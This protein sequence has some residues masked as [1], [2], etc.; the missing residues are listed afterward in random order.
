MLLQT[1]QCLQFG[2]HAKLK[3]N[4][5]NFYASLYRS[6]CSSDEAQLNNFFRPLNIPSIV[7]D[8]SSRL[9][10][11][12]TVEEVKAAL[13]SMQNGKCP[14]PDGLPTEFFKIFADKL[15]PLLL[16]MFNELSRVGRNT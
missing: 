11:P 12:F 3:L 9:N 15:S 4:F 6:E 14:G 5:R 16:N 10:E 7:C 2:R 1:C 8:T 13:F